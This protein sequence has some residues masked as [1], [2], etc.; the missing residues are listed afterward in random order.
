MMIVRTRKPVLLAS[1]VYLLLLLAICLPAHARTEPAH[2]PVDPHH[3]DGSSLGAPIDLSSTWLLHQGDDPRY[4]S[5]R[6]DDSHWL[7]VKAGRSLNSYGL[8]NVDRVWYRTHVRIPA[9]ARDLALLLRGFLGSEQIFVNGVE[10]GSSG[11]FPRGGELPAAGTPERRYSI[12]DSALDSG[13]L[14]I[15]I[16][17]SVGRASEDGTYPAGFTSGTTL[18][19]GSAPRLADTSSLNRFRGYT[20]NAAGLALECLLLIITLALA[21]T[22]RSE[23]EYL[24]LVL[25]LAGIVGRDALGIWMGVNNVVWTD[26]LLVLSRLLQA[27]YWIA[28]L[29]FVRLVL[30]LRRSRL[31]AGYEWLLGLAATMIFFWFQHQAYISASGATNS[32]AAKANLLLVVVFLPYD[33]GLPLLAL[34]VWRK[35]RNPDALLLFVPLLIRAAYG[36]Y[37]LADSLLFRFHLVENQGNASIPV[38]ALDIGWDEV[39]NFLFMVALLVFLVLRTVRLAR[40]RAAIAAEIEAARTMQRLL[41]AG[42]SQRTPGFAVESVYHPASEVGG[43]FFLVSPG[44]DGSL[45]A[46]VGDV[47]GKGLLAAMR[48]SM[49]LGVL[50]REESREPAAVLRG[51]NEALLSQ[52]EMGFTTACCV[53]LDGSGHFTVANAGHIPPYIGGQELAMPSALPLGIAAGQSYEMVDGEL[54]SGQKLVLMSDGVVEARSAKGELYGFERLSQLTLMPAYDIADTAQRFGQEDDITVLTIACAAV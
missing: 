16:G 31:Y 39:T 46:I 7:V 13:D 34:W 18:L 37:S 42:A 29:E 8:K 2:P 53:R 38:Q 23:H 28:L 3:V 20:S 9:G 6:F 44:D 50:R 49:I 21:F 36:Y 22:L 24:A 14:I 54:H 45:T 40:A 5:P 12:P 51:L 25:F 27:L 35:R 10:V 17:A 4:A 43:D 48:V 47:S 26:G 1:A 33:A 19:L 52:G 15:A 11:P 30:G 32:V 41:L